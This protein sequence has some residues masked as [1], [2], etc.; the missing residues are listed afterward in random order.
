MKAPD[1]AAVM[2]STRIEPS[3]YGNPRQWQARAEVVLI[4]DGH[5]RNVGRGSFYDASMGW[6]G[7]IFEAHLSDDSKDGVPY[8][9]APEVEFLGQTV[10]YDEVIQTAHVVAQARRRMDAAIVA[11]GYPANFAEAMVRWAKAMGVTRFIVKVSGDSTSYSENKWS[12][13]KSSEARAWL[14]NRLAAHLAKQMAVT[15]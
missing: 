2:L 13:L 3:K 1:N 14:E 15:T 5:P 10:S 9:H 8:Y 12:V 4:E 7:H 11:D 6:E